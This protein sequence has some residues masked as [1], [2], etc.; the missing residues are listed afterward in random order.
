MAF[1]VPVLL[2]SSHIK[3]RESCSSM[4]VGGVRTLHARV[5]AA[6]ARRLANHHHIR[7]SAAQQGVPAGL[8]RAA[9]QLSNEPDARARCALLV[10]WADENSLPQASR[11]KDMP[12]LHK[13]AATRVPGCTS[14]TYVQARVVAPSDPQKGESR[15]EIVLYGS[16]DAKLTTG[17]LRILA[18]GMAQCS[19]DE[20]LAMDV[21][22]F[23]RSAGLLD[24]LT[25]SR[26]NGLRN[27]VQLIQQQLREETPD[28]SQ[29]VRNGQA[30]NMKSAVPLSS[31]DS[32]MDDILHGRYSGET[33]EEVA[34]LLSGGVDSSVALRLV[35]EQGYKVVPFYLK[36]WLQDELSHLNECPWEE[37]VA[38]ATAVCEQAGLQ[39]HTLDLQHDYWDQVVSYTISEARAGRTPNPDVMCNSRIKFGVFLDRVGKHFKRVASGHY[40]RIEI[41]ETVPGKLLLSRSV[42][43]HKDQ[44]YFL[45]NL[46]TAQLSKAMFPIGMYDKNTVRMLAERF[47]LPNKSRKDSQGICFLGKLPFDAFLEHYL[48]TQAGALVDYDTGIQLGSHRGFWFYTL[49]Q[50]KGIGLAGGP[51]FVV[52]KDPQQN[53]VYVSNKYDAED[54]ERDSFGVQHLNWIGRAS[55]EASLLETPTQ[56]L[57]VKIRHGPK[58]H[59][60]TLSL[61]ALDPSRG[62]VKLEERNSGIAPGQ[63]AVF[64]KGP[65][66]LGSGVIST[67]HGLASAPPQITG[68]APKK[69]QAHFAAD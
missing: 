64:Y 50:R 61:D 35:L 53:I 38:Y 15:Q 65:V 12:A 18:D 2:P 60:C 41:D 58:L 26:N 46:T 11:L 5:A 68:F 17:L 9:Q 42:D 69:L 14:V 20:I 29:V 56:D 36:I 49:G 13:S 3:S 48:G 30:S 22:E 28:P 31:V 43:T 7:C 34:V 66:C 8:K 25:P 6:R 55:E 21:G 52:S 16:S 40:A 44:T 32:T 39:L 24:A 67:D 4:F 10:K 59:K 23:A 27:I 63:F 45:A 51:W 57:I 54:K 62:S 47:D 1:Q 37:D 33:R 19:V